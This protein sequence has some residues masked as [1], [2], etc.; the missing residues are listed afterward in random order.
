MTHDPGNIFAKILRGE[1]PSLKLYD[2]TFAYAFGDIVPRAYGHLLVILQELTRNLLDAST[3]QLSA[4]M[5]T[6]QKLSRA[7]MKAF[8][9]D[10]IALQKFNESAGGQEVFHLHFHVL[11]RHRGVELRPPRTKAQT[12]VLKAHADSIV[13]AL[14]G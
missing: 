2:D 4:C 12:N 1:I 8:Q 6:V 7:A 14:A 5:N 10:G 3:E 13:S 9:A 11:P